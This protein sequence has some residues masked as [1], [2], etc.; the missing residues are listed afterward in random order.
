V[1]PTCT[2]RACEEVLKHVGAGLRALEV[3]EDQQQR[4]RLDVLDRRRQRERGTNGAQQP[5]SGA[6]RGWCIRKRYQH[7]TVR[8]RLLSRCLRCERAAHFHGQAGLAAAAQ[9]GDGC[10]STVWI[11]H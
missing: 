1:K 4:F 5:F 11:G 7:N 2:R 6:V 8:E 10:Q 3:V 9:T